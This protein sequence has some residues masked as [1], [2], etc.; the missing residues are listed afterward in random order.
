MKPDAILINTSRGRTVD[1]V[2]L[3]RALK[4]N[5]IAGAGIDVWYNYPA[6]TQDISQETVLPAPQ[7]FHELTNIV[8]T[9][10]RGGFVEEASRAFVKEAVENV[11]RFVS[12]E[13]PQGL[14]DLKAGY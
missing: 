11:A 10:H 13:P 6:F 7:P 3:Y 8:M 12:G 4:D 1:P 2:A 14:V 9:P 5:R